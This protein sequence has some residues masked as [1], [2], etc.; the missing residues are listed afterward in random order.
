MLRENR[1]QRDSARRIP[2][3]W[4]RQQ[5]PGKAAF[6]RSPRGRRASESGPSR[7]TLQ[8]MTHRCPRSSTLHPAA[9]ALFPEDGPRPSPPSRRRMALVR[10]TRVK[11]SLGDVRAPSLASSDCPPLS[12]FWGY[13]RFQLVLHV[14]MIAKN[15]KVFQINP[16]R[17]G[18]ECQLGAAG[19]TWRG[20]DA[21][22]GGVVLACVTPAGSCVALRA[23]P[24]PNAEPHSR[25]VACAAR[26]AVACPVHAARG[27]APHR[28]LDPVGA[29]NRA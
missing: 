29:D 11:F 3:A 27:N 16:R 15:G 14:R 6:R 10:E 5:W 9:P 2:R 23:T 24:L 21:S 8:R 28:P 20:H 26:P 22:S 25:A 18:A 17:P 12:Y 19:K 7:Q 13:R 4:R 1:F